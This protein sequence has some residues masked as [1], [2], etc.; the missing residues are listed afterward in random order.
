MALT[1]TTQQQEEL[2]V[3]MPAAD[4]LRAFVVALR[5]VGRV[6]SVQEKFG[7][8][9]GSVRAGALNMNKADVTIQVQ[10]DGGAGSKVRLTATAQEGLI[11][12]LKWC[13]SS[14]L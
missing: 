13:E 4:A 1:R 10:A 5:R 9:V 7:R 12:A 6:S 11:Y 8:I 2:P 14:G 3:P